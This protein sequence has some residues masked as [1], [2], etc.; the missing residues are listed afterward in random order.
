MPYHVIIRLPDGR[1][2]CADYREP[3]ARPMHKINRAL[4][5]FRPADP[6]LYGTVAAWL[7]AH[8][9]QSAACHAGLSAAGLPCG[10]D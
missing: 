1:F 9:E 4:S 8:Q 2:A 3:V 6:A 10:H 5:E 7:D